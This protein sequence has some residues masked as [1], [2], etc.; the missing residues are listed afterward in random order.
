MAS[1]Q[2]IA[3]AQFV[4]DLYYPD[5][6]NGPRLPEG[7]VPGIV[8]FVEQL[9]REEQCSPPQSRQQ[10]LDNDFQTILDCGG[11]SRQ[12]VRFNLIEPVFPADAV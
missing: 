3:N 1:D 11:Q 6:V 4:L 5:L 7:A 10:R 2:G 12:R 8:K 9:A